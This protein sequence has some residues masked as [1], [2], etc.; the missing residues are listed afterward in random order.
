MTT[1]G[2]EEIRGRQ[3]VVAAVADFAGLDLEWLLRQ[4]DRGASQEQ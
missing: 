4:C 2:P 1:L 3:E